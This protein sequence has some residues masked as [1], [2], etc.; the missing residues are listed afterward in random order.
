[1]FQENIKIDYNEIVLNFG[2]KSLIDSETLET[3]NIQKNSTIFQ[4]GRLR[5]GILI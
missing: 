3:Y 5:G 4:H 2:G 1:M